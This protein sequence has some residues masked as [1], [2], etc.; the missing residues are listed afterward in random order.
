[1]NVEDMKT[2]LAKVEDPEETEMNS[3]TI[4]DQDYREV[5]RNRFSGIPEDYLSYLMVNGWGAFR[6]CA[7]CIYDQPG[8]PNRLMGEGG[9]LLRQI[10]FGNIPSLW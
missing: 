2:F 1:M 7:G 3:R 8:A 5:L 6:E 10:R 9:L 4:V